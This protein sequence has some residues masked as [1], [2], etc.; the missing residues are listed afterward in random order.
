MHDAVVDEEF[1]SDNEEQ[2]NSADD[3]GE[4]FVELEY[5]RDLSRAALEEHEQE[6]GKYHIDGI[7][8]ASHD[9]MIAVKP[10]PS[11][12]VVAIV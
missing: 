6:R 10:L 9:T 8:F 4:G 2:N 1:A 5:R 7:E 11:A 12:V 3:I